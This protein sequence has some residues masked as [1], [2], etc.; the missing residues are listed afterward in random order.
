MSDQ[1]KHKWNSKKS[2]AKCNNCGCIRNRAFIPVKYIL[3]SG[4]RWMG[5]GAPPCGLPKVSGREL[6]ALMILFNNPFLTPRGFAWKFWLDHKEAMGSRRRGGYYRA[7]GSYLSRLR[8][9]KLVRDSYK[10]DSQWEWYLTE[11]GKQVL[12]NNSKIGTKDDIKI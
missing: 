3:A 10:G 4:R 6:E 11:I 12:T 9:K 7:A 5:D 2:K 1:K 8:D